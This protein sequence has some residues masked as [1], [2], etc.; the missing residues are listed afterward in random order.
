MTQPHDHLR[1]TFAQ[2][3]QREQ[4]LLFALPVERVTSGFDA[5]LPTP[6]RVACVASKEHRTCRCASEI[7]D[8]ARSMSGGRDRKQRTVTEDVD[9]A[10]ELPIRVLREP[11]LL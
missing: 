9:H 10:F 5:M 6:A 7:G 2:G 8:M 1:M 3:L 4:A 11:K